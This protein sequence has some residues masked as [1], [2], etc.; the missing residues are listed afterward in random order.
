MYCILGH[1]NLHCLKQDRFTLSTEG[2]IITTF[3]VDDKCI[4]VCNGTLFMNLIHKQ[5][6][7]FFDNMGNY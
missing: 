1:L 3:S 4:S 7:R 6:N 5:Y 2:H